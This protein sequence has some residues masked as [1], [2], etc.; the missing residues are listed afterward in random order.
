MGREVE[1]DLASIKLGD[2][3]DKN[4]MCESFT[5]KKNKERNGSGYKCQ[6]LTQYPPFSNRVQHPNNYIT[7]NLGFLSWTTH[8]A[9]K[10]G[11]HS[12]D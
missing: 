8:I 10:I 2:K 4:I 12:W 6:C 3:H 11:V 1:K 9:E 7:G 5:K